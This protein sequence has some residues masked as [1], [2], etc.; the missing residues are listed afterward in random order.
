MTSVDF[1]RVFAMSAFEGL[2]ALRLRKPLYPEFTLIELVE[3]VRRVEPDGN[4]HDY[5]AA[6]RLEDTRL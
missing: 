2:R 6:F 5:E 4:S 3:L 1:S